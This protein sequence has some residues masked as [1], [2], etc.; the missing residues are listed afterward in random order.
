MIWYT[1]FHLYGIIFVYNAYV[2]INQIIKTSNANKQHQ[3]SIVIL[4]MIQQYLANE[5]R[6]AMLQ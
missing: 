1:I 5:L 3:S 6:F 4:M 2:L